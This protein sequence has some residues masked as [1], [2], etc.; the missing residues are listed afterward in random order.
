[1]AESPRQGLAQFLKS[2]NSVP[3]SPTPYWE[4]ETDAL[5]FYFKDEPSY[6]RRLNPLMTVFLSAH[7]SRLVG[8]EVK[9]IKR[10]LD[11]IKRI[12][13]GDVGLKVLLIFALVPE[14][15]CP[16]FEVEYSEDFQRLLEAASDADS[17]WPR[18]C[19]STLLARWRPGC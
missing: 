7:D 4:P 19:C 15:D 13:V 6:S 14:P 9:G 10:I 5:I 17:R 2:V 18:S 8:C 3:F 11:R 1:M 12:G 16:K